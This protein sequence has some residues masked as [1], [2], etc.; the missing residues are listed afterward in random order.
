MFH[1]LCPNCFSRV[2]SALHPTALPRLLGL[3]G[4]RRG[5]NGWSMGPLRSDCVR[6]GVRVRSLS[7]PG[8][9][10]RAHPHQSR[11]MFRAGVILCLSSEVPVGDDEAIAV[12]CVIDPCAPEE[13]LLLLAVRAHPTGHCLS[14]H[15][16]AVVYDLHLGP[17]VGAL[18]REGLEVFSI[19][20]GI[21]HEVL[22]FFVR[23]DFCDH[24]FFSRRPRSSA[25]SCNKSAAIRER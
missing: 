20:L 4:V 10:A 8:A 3:S 19:L 18:P 6:G 9:P 25:F 2:C 24:H 14:A 15:A 17:A 7:L 1:G 16:G 11:L 13:A 21:I 23:Q 12:P 22:D 5:Y